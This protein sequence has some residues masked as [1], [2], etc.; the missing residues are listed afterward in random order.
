[1]PSTLFLTVGFKSE[2]SSLKICRG[3]INANT[4]CW[5]FLALN[6]ARP[7]CQSKQAYPDMELVACA[8]RQG[9]RPSFT[10]RAWESDG[11][12]LI[13]ASSQWW[14][15]S[16]YLTP[17]STPCCWDLRWIWDILTRLTYSNTSILHIMCVFNY[18][19]CI[20]MIPSIR[21]E[22]DKYIK[23]WLHGLAAR[24]PSR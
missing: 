4:R 17:S 2:R 14:N 8:I 21:T 6:L 7:S 13:K 18:F 12:G 22:I 11:V 10:W 19:T 3:T 15:F 24:L 20:S 1:M 23:H 5:R 16:R 9:F